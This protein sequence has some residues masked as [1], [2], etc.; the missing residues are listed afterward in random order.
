MAIIN[1][2]VEFALYGNQADT[3]DAGVD[4]D[5][6]ALVGT[7]TFT[8]VTTSDRPILAST[9][10]PPAGFILRPIT[11]YI[12]SD[13]ILRASRSGP[14]GVRLWANDP[15][16]GLTTLSYK[17]KFDM[18]TTPLGEVVKV[19]GGYFTAPE[20]DRVLNLTEVL[21]TGVSIGGPRI[22]GG[23]FSDGDV[24]FENQDGTLLD[25]IEIPAGTLVFV[26]NGDGTWS[27][28]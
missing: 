25:P 13:G 27:V 18:M 17:V 11:G 19:D 12:D 5:Q 14:E 10:D 28:G 7:V 20:D 26:D 6:I 1:F 9:Y 23:T 2:T 16:F 3:D 24:I 22:I 4:A 15:V 21:Q 8:P